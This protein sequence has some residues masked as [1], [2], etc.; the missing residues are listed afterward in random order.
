MFAGCCLV[1]CSSFAGSRAL[2]VMC[3]LFCVVCGVA[4]FAAFGACGLL[5]A[6]LC[7]GVY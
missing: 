7:F 5:V 4:C 1:C 2:F 6:M 3:C